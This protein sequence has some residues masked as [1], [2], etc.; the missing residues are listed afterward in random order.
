MPQVIVLLAAGA[1]LLL[2]RKWFKTAQDRVAAD[3]REAR[4]AMAEHQRRESLGTKL[5]QD[6]ATGIYRPQQSDLS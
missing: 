5:E 2:A 3:L 1:G 4:D 6:P